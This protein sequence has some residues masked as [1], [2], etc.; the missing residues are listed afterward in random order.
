[1]QQN[2]GFSMAEAAKLL[3]TPEGK[4]LSGLLQKDG[5]AAMRA[6]FSAFQ[7]GNMDEVQRLLAPMLSDPKAEALLRQLD[8]RR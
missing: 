7:E 8:G 4:Q 1:M 3:A 5:G 6:A 2:S